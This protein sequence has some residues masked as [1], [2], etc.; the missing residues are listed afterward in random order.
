VV[1]RFYRVL[2]NLLDLDA[3]AGCLKCAD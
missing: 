2:R 1:R 3:E